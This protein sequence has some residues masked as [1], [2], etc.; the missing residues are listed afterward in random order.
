MIFSKKFRKIFCVSHVYGHVNVKMPI[1]RC[2]IYCVKIK[3]PHIDV[4]FRKKLKKTFKK[5]LTKGVVRGI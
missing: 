5:V 3:D 1:R 2:T 4:V